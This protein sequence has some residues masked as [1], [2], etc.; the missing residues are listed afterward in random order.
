LAGLCCKARRGGRYVRR[1]AG[2][3]ARQ[4]PAVSPD[5][6]SL[7]ERWAGVGAPGGQQGDPGLDSGEPGDGARLTGAMS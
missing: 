4:G 2:R 1:Q 5:N 7:Y 6:L 3:V